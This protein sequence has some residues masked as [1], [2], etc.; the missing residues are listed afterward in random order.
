MQ[1]AWQDF[2]L[3]WAA[4]APQWESVRYPVRL[5]CRTAVPVVAAACLAA[6]SLSQARAPERA[7]RLRMAN[8]AASLFMNAPPGGRLR[9]CGVTQGLYGQEGPES[10]KGAAG[11]GGLP[12]RSMGVGRGGGARA[13]RE[14][15]AHDARE[16]VDVVRLLHVPERPV[17]KDL[18]GGAL[19]GEAAADHD[20]HRGVDPLHLA[21]AF[22]AA[23]DRHRQVEEDEIDVPGMLA[24]EPQ[25]L[26]AVARG[27]DPVAVKLQDVL[28]ERQ[29]RRFVVDRQDRPARGR[30][31][32]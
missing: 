19:R 7:T 31:R 16:E 24:V 12:R 5:T 30:A 11:R 27:Q 25:R 8:S 13:L 3:A 22:H 14:G 17:A 20:P 1:L 26:L 32:V 23:Q 6:S 4:A 28:G 2:P 18:G 9:E 29:H 10:T 15:L 21:E